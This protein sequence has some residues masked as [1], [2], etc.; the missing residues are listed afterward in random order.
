L[1]IL[2][3]GGG[4]LKTV[5]ET[6]NA[7][8]SQILEETKARLNRMFCYG[9]TTFEVKTGYGLDLESEKRLLQIIE[10]LSKT[11]GFDVAPTLLSAHA[12]PPEYAGREVQYIEDVVRPSIDFASENKLAR[13][14]DVFMEK[15][16]FDRSQARQILVHAKSK[17]L[18]LKIHADEFSDLGGARLASELKVTSAD[19]LM[20]A[21]PE[22]IRELAESSIISVL[23]PGTSLSSF[24]SSFAKARDFI[25]NR[26][27]VALATDL[28]PNSWIESMQFVMSLACY[29]MHMTPV[30]ALVGATIN[31]A[32]AIGKAKDVGSIEVGKKCDLAIMNLSNYEEIPYRIGTNNVRIVIKNG[33]LVRAVQI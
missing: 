25:S 2:E 31:G 26:C 4:I 16:V 7:S 3:K 9:T 12:V 30:E 15:G 10:Q 33:S 22:G 24:A 21:S 13:F 17:N 1:Q 14:C 27:P 5:R 11:H 6:R 23:L 20:Q 8:D 29:E 28:S 18:G 32:H 19:H